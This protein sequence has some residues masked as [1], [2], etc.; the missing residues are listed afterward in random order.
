MFGGGAMGCVGPNQAISISRF[1]VSPGS[2]FSSHFGVLRLSQ[3][4]GRENRDTTVDTTG[5]PATRGSGFS[6]HH[7]LLTAPNWR[8]PLG[9]PFTTLPPGVAAERAPSGARFV[10]SGAESTSGPESGACP[11][12]THASVLSAVSFD[13]PESSP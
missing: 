8:T 9:V 7:A 3:G 6:I 11:G 4:T 10:E 2:L 13:A 12:P 1:C 5:P